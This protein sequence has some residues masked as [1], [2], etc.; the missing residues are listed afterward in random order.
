MHNALAALRISGMS[1]SDS[2]MVGN[3]EFL[4][5]THTGLT[6]IAS[7][8]GNLILNDVLVCPE[9]AKPLLSVS[10]FTKD[11]PCGFDFDAD[12]VR[13]YD[14]ATK[15]VLLRGRNTKGLYSLKEPIAKALITSRQVTASDEI[16]HQR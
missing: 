10:K 13:V 8:S 16:W 9:I 11:Y 4:P 5:I 3:G 2:V 12:C 15:K 1:E 7:T 6:S 14:K